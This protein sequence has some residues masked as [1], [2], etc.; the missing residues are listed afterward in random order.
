[1]PI[2]KQIAGHGSCVP[3]QKYLEKKNR[4]LARDFVNIEGVPD[5]DLIAEPSMGPSI[6]WAKH[7]D[8]YRAEYG[9]DLP[10]KGR[11]A[12]TFKHFVLSPAPEDDIDLQ[13]LREITSAWVR[14][15]FDEFQV[16]VVYHDDN[17]SHIPHAHIVVNNTN[18]TTGKRMH[19]DD[20]RDLNRGLQK[21][22]AERGLH[23]LSN[24]MPEPKTGFE[25]LAAAKQKPVPRPATLQDDYRSRAERRAEEQDGYSWVADIRSRVN[26]AKNLARSETEFIRILQMM[27]VEVSE[28]SSNTRRRDWIFS[29]ADTPTQRVSGER[30]GASYGRQSLERKFVRAGVE[31]LSDKSSRELLRIARD[32]VELKN[33]DELN[34]LSNALETCSRWNISS[35]DGASVVLAAQRGRLENAISTSSRNRINANIERIERARDYMREH[36]V[37]PKHDPRGTGSS[38][39]GTNWTNESSPS[40]WGAPDREQARDERGDWHR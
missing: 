12:R 10:W 34:E 11:A 39:T 7:M 15:Y 36:G 18:V 1:M 35:A 32:A 37:L 24:E 5:T 29:L 4:A 23:A 17:D 13:T 40:S 14:K 9:N 21:L 2:L 20:A 19:H 27:G 8:A 3:V 16:A 22:A 28:N 31:H 30:L 33:L 6:E 26:V 25:R 38:G